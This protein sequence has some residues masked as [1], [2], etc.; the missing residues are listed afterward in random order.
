[1]KE[2]SQKVFFLVA[3]KASILKGILQKSFAFEL[4]NF[5]FETSFADKLRFLR[6]SASTIEL[7]RF[8]NRLDFKHIFLPTL[9]LH[10][11]GIQ[12]ETYCLFVCWC[13][14]TAVDF[15]LAVRA[16]SC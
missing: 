12:V 13:L 7:Q 10:G 9:L 2:V 15:G 16:M 1:M 6:F 4:Q 5:F 3:S 8:R 14:C 11:Q